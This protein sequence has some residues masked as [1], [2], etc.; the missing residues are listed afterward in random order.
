[1]YR[2]PDVTYGEWKPIEDLILDT[3]SYYSGRLHGQ[4]G[5]AE[6]ILKQFCLKVDEIRVGSLIARLL[7]HND[8]QLSHLLRNLHSVARLIR[9]DVVDAAKLKGLVVSYVEKVEDKKVSSILPKLFMKL[10]D[11]LRIQISVNQSSL[12]E[13]SKSGSVELT[14]RVV[15]SSSN[16][17][18]LVMLEEDCEKIE[19]FMKPLVECTPVYN[20]LQGA[21]HAMRSKLHELKSLVRHCF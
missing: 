12:L 7:L 8:L 20:M 16:S 5:S 9:T 2:D 10:V 1:M 15:M 3:V 13:F 14:I 11:R 6:N 17:P 19:Q 18:I 4:T 21:L